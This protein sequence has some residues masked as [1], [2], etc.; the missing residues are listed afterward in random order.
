MVKT[1]LAQVKQYKKYSILAP[2]FVII[3][4]VM[5][6]MIPYLMAD[7]IDKGIS[8]GDMSVIIRLGGIMIGAAIISLIAGVLS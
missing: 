4:V 3:E 5:E 7:L 2:I 1:L 8:A 6:V